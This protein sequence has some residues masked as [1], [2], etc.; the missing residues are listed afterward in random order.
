MSASSKAITLSEDNPN[1]IKC[2]RGFTCECGYKGVAPELLVEEDNATMYCPQCRC[3][4]WI[5]D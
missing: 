3:A 2:R 5:W 1:W 4:G